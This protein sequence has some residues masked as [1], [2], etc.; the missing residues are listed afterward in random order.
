MSTTLSIPQL[1]MGLC[2]ELRLL[3]L[4]PFRVSIPLAVA[5]VHVLFRYSC[6]ETS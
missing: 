3:K 4:S 5:G 6:D 1:H 2:V